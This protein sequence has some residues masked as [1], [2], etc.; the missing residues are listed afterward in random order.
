MFDRI[1]TKPGAQGI[2]QQPAADRR[3]IVADVFFDPVGHERLP[4]CST[5]P[6]GAG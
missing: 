4:G 1:F 5:L 3:G 2:L 6:T